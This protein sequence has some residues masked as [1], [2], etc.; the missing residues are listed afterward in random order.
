MASKKL[1]T[2]F[3]ATGAQG[4]A[5]ANV[6]LHDVKLKPQW[7]VRAVTRDTTKPSANKLR[8]EGAEVV[9]VRNPI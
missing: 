4:G 3:G 6:F 1:I 5:V 8:D 9:S 2:V 7:V